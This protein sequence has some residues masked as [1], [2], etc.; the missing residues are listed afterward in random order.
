MYAPAH[1]QAEAVNGV[2]KHVHRGQLSADDA[3]ECASVLTDAPVGVVPLPRLMERAFDRAMGLRITV[4]DALY[5]ALAEA[6]GL[7][8]ISDD[9]ELLR[10]ISTDPALAPLALHVGDL[11]SL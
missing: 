4:Y 8:L 9:R 7:P 6:R 2:W 3:R 11:P 1:W 5:L 10:R